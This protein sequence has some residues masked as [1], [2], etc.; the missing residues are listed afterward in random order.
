[1]TEGERTAAFMHRA[2]DLLAARSMPALDVRRRSVA[3][4]GGVFTGR[5]F[6]T[7]EVARTTRS[8]PALPD[9]WANH[10]ELELP[11]R[12]SRRY[13]S[14]KVDLVQE[15][16]RTVVLKGLDPS[17][18]RNADCP[19]RWAVAQ[20]STPASPPLS[21]AAMAS[22]ERW[23][24]LRRTDHS[25]IHFSN[26]CWGARPDGWGYRTGFAAY[27]DAS[28]ARRAARQ[29]A[30]QDLRSRRT[31]PG[32]GLIQANSWVG[33]AILGEWSRCGDHTQ[34]S[35]PGRSPSPW[36]VRDIGAQ[37]L[38][39]PCPRLLKMDRKMCSAHYIE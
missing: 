8:V 10:P 1:M 28:V 7:D 15:G 11:P 12:G 16:F 38:V 35:S 39:A 13:G 20:W 31:S 6:P 19:A 36:W 4:R 18:G 34:F 9:A 26:D 14:G 23:K 21:G 29:Q 17:G 27:G 22:L 30:Q 25:D 32:L 3:L 2:R 24:D 33:L 5:I 37:N